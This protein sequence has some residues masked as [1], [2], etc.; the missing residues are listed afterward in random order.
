VNAA[1]AASV[2]VGFGCIAVALA[3]SDGHDSNGPLALVLCALAAWGASPFVRWH[4]S[5]RATATL[6]WALAIAFAI[7]NLVLAPGSYVRLDAPRWPFYALTSLELMLL[8]SYGR[9]IWLTRSPSP[10][11]ADLRRALLAGIAAVLGAWMLRMSPAPRIDVWV[12]HQQAAEALLHGRSIYANGVIETLDTHTFARSIDTYAYPPLDALL[13]AAAF[14]LTGE[15]RWACLVAQ[16]AAAVLVWRLAR[17]ASPAVQAW[18][19]LLAALLL[20]FPRG[21]FV[22]EQA[23]GEPLALPFLGGFALA[24]AR[25]KDTLAAVLLG[26]LFAL[27][28]YFLLFAPLLLLPGRRARRALIAAGVAAGTVV[29]FALVDPAGLWHGLVTHHLANPFRADSLSLPAAL[30]TSGVLLPSWVGIAASVVPYALLL[31]LRRDLAALLLVACLS[32]LCFFAFGRQAFC[33]YYYLVCGAALV[34]L[35]DTEASAAHHANATS[36]A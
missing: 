28:Q 3:L 6:G 17:R 29:P 22:L 31:R 15:I 20:F 4:L 26:L 11:F 25:R 14:A 21:L 19:E 36:T 24:H 23:W 2:I 30:S 33:N 1:S 18:G 13:T 7:F 5:W 12:V 34:A 10:V 9:E 32:L 35:A 16:L 8:A 27:K